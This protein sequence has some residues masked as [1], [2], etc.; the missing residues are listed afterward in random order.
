MGLRTI[1]VLLV[2]VALVA[3]AGLYERHLRQRATVI[4][5]TLPALVRIV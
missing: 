2:L 1:F 4:W 5:L 3:A